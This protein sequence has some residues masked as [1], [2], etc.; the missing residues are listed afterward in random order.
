[1]PPRQKLRAVA[2]DETAP[3]KRRPRSIT[4]AAAAGDQK[5]LLVALRERVAKAVEDP[6]CPPRDLAALSRRLQEIGRDIEAIEARERQEA[7]EDANG[8]P[9]EAWDAEAL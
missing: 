7:A 5:V 2:A 3:S 6:N 4:E 8:H 1:V 9:D